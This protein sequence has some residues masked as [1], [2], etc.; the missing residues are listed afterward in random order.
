MRKRNYETRG[1]P[2]TMADDLDAARKRIRQLE[3]E[4]ARLREALTGITDISWD[5]FYGDPDE[6]LN[7]WIRE[8]TSIARDALNGGESEGA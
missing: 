2:W 4:N 3:A 6:R 7:D 1:G 5:D 8:A